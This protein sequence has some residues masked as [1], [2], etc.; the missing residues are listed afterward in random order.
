MSETTLKKVLVAYAVQGEF[1]ELEWNDAYVYYVRTGIG[2]VKSAFHLTE[3]I[4]QVHPDIVINMGTA[5]T[6]KHKVG[7]IFIC[8]RFIDRDMRKLA[9]LGLESEIDSCGLLSEMGCLLNIDTSAVCNTGDS[10]MT[11]VADVEGDVVDMEAYAQAFVC[12][13][14]NVP[15]VSVKYVSDILGRNSV[16][17]WEDKLADS[18]KALHLFMNKE[19]NHNLFVR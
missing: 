6:V 2:K 19:E 12:S 17:H 7:D 15:F 18:R 11:D 4:A 10:F 14:M 13:R 1:V 9:N 3:A 16:K 5:G 8:H